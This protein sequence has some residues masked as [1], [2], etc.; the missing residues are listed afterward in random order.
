MTRS[1]PRTPDGKKS[2]GTD[3]S[4]TPPGYPERFTANAPD[5]SEMRPETP[6]EFTRR[7]WIYYSLED[8]EKAEK[9][10]RQALVE[11]ERN[12]DILYPLGL[13]LKAAGKADEALKVFHLGIAEIEKRETTPRISM[14]RHLINTQIQH[15]KQGYLAK[16]L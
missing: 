3:R 11:D 2:T 1:S 9:D 7:G 10:F 8:Y 6:E 5:L 16:E 13:T 15:V 4:T 12:V 14:L